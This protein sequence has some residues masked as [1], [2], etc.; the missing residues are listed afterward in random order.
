MTYISKVGLSLHAEMS[1]GSDTCQPKSNQMMHIYPVGYNILP[2]E[3]QPGFGVVDGFG[4][5]GQKN[6]EIPGRGCRPVV[7]GLLGRSLLRLGDRSLD[8]PLPGH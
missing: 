4:L 5:L 8:S 7:R 3:T 1:M 6:V 2:H